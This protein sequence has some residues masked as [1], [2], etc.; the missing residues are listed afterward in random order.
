MATKSHPSDSTDPQPSNVRRLPPGYDYI[1]TL[2]DH[3]QSKSADSEDPTPRFRTYNEFSTLDSAERERYY[4]DMVK[5]LETYPQRCSYLDLKI[6]QLPDGQGG[7]LL[8][9]DEE[10]EAELQRKDLQQKWKLPKD[11]GSGRARPSGEESWDDGKLHLNDKSQF[12]LCEECWHAPPNEEDPLPLHL[13]DDYISSQL[14]F[15]RVAIYVQLLIGG[16]KPWDIEFLHLDGVS[17]VRFYDDGGWPKIEFR[18]RGE[19][20]EDA[21]KLVN[22][23]TD[24][25]FPHPGGVIAG[26]VD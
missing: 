15:Y 12:E 24:L 19:S 6:C 17:T 2:I 5:A 22:F 16:S 8:T 18:G 13:F 25:K 21:L 20:Q 10:R 26:T 1:Q 11:R 14:L 4:N 23:L 7:N 3:T 9:K